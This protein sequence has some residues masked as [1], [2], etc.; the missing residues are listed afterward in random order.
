MVVHT[1]APVGARRPNDK[2][3]FGRTLVELEQDPRHPSIAPAVQQIAVELLAEPER[4]LPPFVARSMRH[5]LDRAEVPVSTVRATDLGPP[6]RSL[7]G[8]R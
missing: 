4:P 1:Y 8:A 5:C 3:P 6:V 2:A 7:A